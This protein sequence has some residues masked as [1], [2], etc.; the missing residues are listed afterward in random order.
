MGRRLDELD[1]TFRPLAVEFL[2]RLTEAGVPVKIVSTGR[3][4]TEQA[5]A[6][7]RGA[8]KVER[9]RHQDGMAIDVVPY[10]IF[11]LAGPDKLQWSTADPVWQ[12]IGQ[13]AESLGLRWGG[14]FGE[15]PA[16]AGN[17]WDPGHVEIPAVPRA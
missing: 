4:A 1:P 2:A 15:K 17:G 5:E 12:T 7:R 6:V 13:I 8:S 16:G 10:D 3:T 14:R 11:Q 9:S